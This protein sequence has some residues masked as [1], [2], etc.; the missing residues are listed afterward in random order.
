[1]GKKHIVLCFALLVLKI[2]P[3]YLRRGD[4]GKEPTFL[5]F[6][7]KSVSFRIGGTGVS[8]YVGLGA[9]DCWIFNSII[10]CIGGTTYPVRCPS[11][12][13]G[14]GSPL[15]QSHLAGYAGTPLWKLMILW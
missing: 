9:G 14:F 7:L 6:A 5:C 12:S 3:G 10:F 2:I 4:R 15:C 8:G 13:L 11:L 1:M